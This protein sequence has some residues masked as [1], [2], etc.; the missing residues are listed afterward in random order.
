MGIR[1]GNRQDGPRAQRRLPAGLWARLY[2]DFY[3]RI[4]GYF[5]ARRLQRAD[6]EDLAMQVFEELGR[7]KTPRDP[8]PYI[9]VMAR[10]LLARYRRNK[11]KEASALHKVLAEEAAKDGTAHLSRQRR[12][13]AAYRETLEAIA[14]ALSRRQRELLRL[15][16]ADNLSIEKLAAR[17][18]CSKP[19]VY[20]RIYRLRKRVIRG[21]RGQPRRAPAR[22]RS[23]RGGPGG[24]GR[25]GRGPGS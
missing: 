4:E 16:F 7:S 9:R 12:S 19:A 17:L 24:P 8:G 1:G 11:A 3:P 25:A 15:R 18:G 22:G 5:A 6:A 23:G 2:A 20:K 14:A 21:S 13:E 10:N